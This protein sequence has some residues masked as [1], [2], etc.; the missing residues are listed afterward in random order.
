MSEIKLSK[1]HIPENGRHD[2]AYCIDVPY[3]KGIKTYTIF[4]YDAPKMHPGNLQMDIK[5]PELS[6]FMRDEIG[7]FTRLFKGD[8]LTV[9]DDNGNLILSFNRLETKP[10]MIVYQEPSAPFIHILSAKDAKRAGFTYE[11]KSPTARTRNKIKKGISF[12]LIASAL[13]GCCKYA[14]THSQ[15]I[16][17]KSAFMFEKITGTLRS[18]KQTFDN[19]THR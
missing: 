3:K 6:Y 9:A 4:G 11:N 15:E 19:Q 7:M 17:G 10:K 12:L 5:H 16:K 18:F 8:I 2:Y 13:F 14:D 1:T